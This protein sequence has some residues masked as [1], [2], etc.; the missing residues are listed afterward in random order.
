MLNISEN[1]VSE[2]RGKLAAIEKS[3]LSSDTNYDRLENELKKARQRLVDG[4]KE[5]ERSQSRQGQG[6]S[7]LT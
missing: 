1:L 7:R 3:T 6:R 2:L 5:K 4:E